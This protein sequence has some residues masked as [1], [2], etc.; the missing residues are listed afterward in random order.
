MFAIAFT[1]KL[2]EIEIYCSTNS[3]SYLNR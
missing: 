2:V 1:Y 3:P